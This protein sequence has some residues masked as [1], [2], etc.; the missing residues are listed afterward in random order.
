MKILDTT[1]RDG[2]YAVDFKFTCDD[3]KNIVSR[4]EKLGFEFIEIG[5]GLGLSASSLE[6]GI[7]L[8]SDIEYIDAAKSV[9]I[10][11]KIGVF[12]IPG[13]A[14]LSDLRVAKEHG[15]SFVRIGI[16]PNQIESAI[17]YIREA[18]DNGIIVMVNFMK[19]YV[20]S[21][22][23]FAQKA[24]YIKDIGA[25]Y[26]Y[27]VDSAGCMLPDEISEYYYAAKTLDSD[28]KLGFHGHN[29]LGLA[30][31]NSIH[32]YELGF[33]IVDSSYQG[34]GRSLGNASTEMLVMTLEKKFGRNAID[35]DIPRLLEYGYAVIKD[36]TNR[37]AINPLDLVC[38]YAGF[39]SSFLKDIYKCCCMMKVDPLRLIIAYSAENRESMDYKRL[40]EIAKGLPNDPFD[41]H[42]YNFRQYF[43][44][45]YNDR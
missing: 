17:D 8:C 39:H 33:D 11:A 42:P 34:L 26:V 25:E 19:T 44:T 30:V 14:K 1:I 15:I 27:I 12:C 24:K 40:C 37:A 9:S 10:N 20:M 35:M 43:S 45:I 29:N 31:S 28:L 32:C 18:K 13:I 22:V 16:N 21:P 23:E 6:R 3:V 2:S 36:I 38:G 5:H 41:S 4:S 7:S